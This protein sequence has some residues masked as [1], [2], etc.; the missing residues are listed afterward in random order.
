MPA[1]AI[2]GVA[3]EEENGYT[4]AKLALYT[5]F[6]CYSLCFSKRV[7]MNFYRMAF[8]AVLYPQFFKIVG[9]FVSDMHYYRK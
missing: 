2:C 4:E 5:H 1:C 8:E 6:L 9:V 3:L 7:L